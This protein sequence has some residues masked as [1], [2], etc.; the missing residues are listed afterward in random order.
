MRVLLLSRYGPLGASSRM[1]SY[2]YLPYLSELG[3]HVDVSPLLDDIYLENFYRARKTPYRSLLK[4]YFTRTL[5]ILRSG[6]YQ[7]LWIEKELF[8]WM[9]LWFD[10]ILLQ[11]RLPYV[12]DY[13]DAIFHRYD[14]HPRWLIRTFLGN[15]IDGV[16]KGASTVI[17][18]NSYLAARAKAS[19]AVCVEV[20]P[21]AVDLCRYPKFPAEDNDCFTVGWIGTP[22]TARYLGLIDTVLGEFL[23]SERAR[24]FI[25]GAGNFSLGR[26]EVVHR[27][28]NLNT[29]TEDLANIDVGIM[30][31]ADGPWEQGKCG[32]KLIHYMACFKPVIASPVGVNRTIVIQGKNGFLAHDPASWIRALTLL[33]HDT[34]LRRR[35][36]NEGR[37]EVENRY[38]T[39]VT[40]P[41]LASILKSAVCIP[42]FVH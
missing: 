29:E 27:T 20:L 14:M 9:P 13:D 34:D 19:G 26:G 3:I 21:T 42:E 25:I 33:K 11:K 22:V 15:K 23:T 35:L 24:L 10:E 17:A 5:K 37:R 2:Q 32:F 7:L 41:K 30:P 1:R 36:G 40:A 12:V 6:K 39:N 31:L 8:P 18:G 4:S 28:W 16:M 38:C